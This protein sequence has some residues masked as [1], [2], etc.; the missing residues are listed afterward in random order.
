[1]KKNFTLSTIIRRSWIIAL[2]AAIFLPAAAQTSHV[3]DVTNNVFTPNELTIT[4]GDTVI[5][6]NSEGRHN[7]NGTQNTYPSNPESFGNEVATGW[8]FTHAF[9]I[10]GLY[11]YRCD[12]HVQSQMFGT[13]T[14][15]EA[16]PDTLTINFSG[17]TPHVGQMGMFLIYDEESGEEIERSGA[18]IEES[19]SMTVP[20]IR[21][22]HDYVI[23]IFV[24]HNSN[25]YY[26]APPTDHAWRMELLNANGNETINFIHNTNFTD[27][28]WVH[29]AILNLSGMNV[30][31]GED[32]HFALVETESGEIV[33]M[34]SEI[35]E[36]A[37]TIELSELVPGMAYHVD[38]YSDHSYDGVYNPPPT[39]HAWR[40][41][42]EMAAGDDILDFVHH[43]NFTDVRSTFGPDIG[44]TEDT[45]LGSFLSD[46]AGFTLYYF[47]NDT[48][49]GTSTCTAGCLD[50]WPVFY[51]ESPELSTGL[52]MEDFG[53]I[54]HP[55]GGMQ[56]TYNGWP[57]YYYVNDLNPGETNGDGLGDVW[58]VAIQDLEAPVY[59]SLEK[60]SMLSGLQIYP[61]PASDMLTIS[62]NEN[63]ESVSL[64]TVT[65][66]RIRFISDLRTDELSLDIA[67]L[68]PGVYFIEVRSENQKLQVSR[69]V[70][71]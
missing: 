44:L 21:A 57:L 67:D 12:P 11:D 26:D 31:F 30:H 6:T 35:V 71:R 33:D 32:I 13:I 42:I 3:V 47:A 55:D 66:S 64:L 9:N 37:F 50:N 22:G 48:L 39:D 29:R 18:T 63:I 15:L 69:V 34:R 60:S 36:D 4:E 70:K 24:D 28:E 7:V 46:K 17:M 8:T 2:L 20:G 25:G 10:P 61:N 41:E 27:I 54:E 51:I 68:A 23:D 59:T 45:E 38:F 40:H 5:W 1:M 19:F 52:N 43:T 62:A 49:N 14:V 56:T 58:F 16:I 65:G 53:S